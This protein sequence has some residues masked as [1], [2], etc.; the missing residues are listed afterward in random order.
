MAVAAVVLVL[1]TGCQSKP[2]NQSDKPDSH[3]ASNDKSNDKSRDDDEPGV[4][5]KSD[6]QAR[7]GLRTESLTERPLHPELIAYGKLLADPAGSFVIRASSSGTLRASRERWP[8][9]G[10]NIPTGTAIGSIEPRLAPSDRVSLNTQLSTARA[11]LNASHTSVS[12]AQ[13]A[14]DRARALNA[15][16]KNVSDRAVQEAASKLAAEQAREAGLRT[17]VATLERATSASGLEGQP[18]T[19]DQGGEVTEALAQPGEWVE[20]GAPIFRLQR[21][22]RLLARVNLAVGDN[23]PSGVPALIVPAGYENMAPLPAAS[24]GVAAEAD[25]HTQGLPLLFRLDRVFPGLRPGIA[26]TAR[27]TLPGTTGEGVLVPRSALVQYEGRLWVYLQTKPDRFTRRPVPA[28][29]PAANG[30]LAAHGFAAGDRVVVTGAQT[31]L[32]EEFKSQNED[33]N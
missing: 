19:A 2:D 3:A 22:D 8:A 32:S 14:Y 15:D 7:A 26:V 29:L 31:L 24:V 11:D 30:L 10:Q 6:A 16:N 4:T 17:S 25:A 13:T 27:F 21:F 5:L 23:L 18:V 1:F 33:T 9:I 20:Q 12:A 28:D